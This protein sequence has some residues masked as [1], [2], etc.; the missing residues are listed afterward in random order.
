[1]LDQLFVKMAHALQWSCASDGKEPFQR[2]HE[3]TARPMRYTIFDTPILNKLLR[4]QAL[5]LLKIFG[6]RTK[7]R[8]PDCRKYVVIVVPHTSNWDLP[9]GLVL[10][11]ALKIKPYWM[12]KDSIFRW[13]F[14]TLFKWL[15]GIPVVR[16]KPTGMVQQ[17][18]QVLRESEEM[19]LAIAPEGTRARTAHWKS[20]FYHIAKGAGVPIVLAFM[21]F[22]RKVGGIGP[23]IIP[24][25]DIEADMKKIRA[26]YA[27]VE[28]RHPERWSEAT[29][30][31]LL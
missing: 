2:F 1:M 19:V 11:F 12:G 15:G 27:G 10:A 21:D 30:E 14:G 22:R 23:A 13:P 4:W 16:S 24:T 6:W 9:V 26:F 8:L 3:R 7:G 29:V 5:L 28:P 17:S 18:I 25:G 20:G 31:P